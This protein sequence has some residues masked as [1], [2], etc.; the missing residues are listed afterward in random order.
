M[1]TKRT[2]VRQLAD[3]N[4]RIRTLVDER[5]HAIGD[6]GSE[7]FNT[8]RLAKQLS[9]ARDENDLLRREL[10]AGRPAAPAPDAWKAER[11]VLRRALHL[12]DRACRSLTQ[13]IADLQAANEALCGEAADRATAA[14]STP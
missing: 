14:V 13:Q 7:H 12:R 5:D 6:A 11:S 3:A 8:R 10:A 9:E 4:R 1:P 2:L